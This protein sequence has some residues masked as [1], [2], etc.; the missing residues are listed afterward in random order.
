M[1]TVESGSVGCSLYFV[2]VL[3]I[4]YLSVSQFY[5]IFTSVMGIIYQTWMLG[6]EKNG[7]LGTV[8]FCAEIVVQLK[9]QVRQQSKLRFQDRMYGSLIYSGHWSIANSML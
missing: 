5:Y 3:Y 2:T 9:F 8:L 6:I 1:R 4:A 7:E